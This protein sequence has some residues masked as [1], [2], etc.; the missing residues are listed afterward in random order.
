MFTFPEVE[1]EGSS[2]SPG[3]FPLVEPKPESE[4]YIAF[5]AGTEGKPKAVSITH[6][7]AVAVSIP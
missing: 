7:N 4:L 3:Q 1:E 2:Q 5:T 6:A